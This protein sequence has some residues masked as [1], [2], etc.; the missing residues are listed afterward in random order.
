MSAVLLN[1]RQLVEMTTCFSSCE[2][3]SDIQW[4]GSWLVPYG[5]SGEGKNPRSRGKST[6][7]FL[8][9]QLEALSQYRLMNPAHYIT[10]MLSQSPH[11]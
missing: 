5:F 6:T 3:V 9:V 10:G 2:R 11:V 7:D 8:V 1:F 4:A